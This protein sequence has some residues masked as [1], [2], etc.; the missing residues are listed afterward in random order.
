MP[1]SN[2]KH[3]QRLQYNSLTLDNKSAEKKR[4]GNTIYNNLVR[5]S[6]PSAIHLD[7]CFVMLQN[8]A[9]KVLKRQISRSEYLDRHHLETFWLMCPNVDHCRKDNENQFK[10]SIDGNVT[11][12][13]LKK[14]SL[15]H[16]E[17]LQKDEMQ[18][19][20]EYQNATIITYSETGTASPQLFRRKLKKSS[21]MIDH[22]YKDNYSP[23]EG[24]F[25]TSLITTDH[26]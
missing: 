22:N 1:S 5:R 9:E 17:S 24:T 19:S 14:P 8:V 15:A 6:R 2:I 21:T 7:G 25:F 10:C 4:S 20:P 16:P 12:C 3:F 23:N 18:V 11:K 13:L 26:A